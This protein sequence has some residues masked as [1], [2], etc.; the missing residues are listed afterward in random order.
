VGFNREWTDNAQVLI[1]TFAEEMDAQ[2]NPRPWTQYDLGQ[3]AAY[4]SIRAHTDGLFV[5][6]MSGIERDSLRALPGVEDRFALFS[7]IALDK[8]GGASALSEKLKPQEYAPRTRRSFTETVIA[9][10]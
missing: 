8:L 9:S 10:G 1:A 7:V 2:I 3:A 5:H 6:Q 4:L